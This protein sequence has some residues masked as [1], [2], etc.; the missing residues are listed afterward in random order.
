MD[1][2]LVGVQTLSCDGTLCRQQEFQ[3][4]GAGLHWPSCLRDTPFLP[5]RSSADTALESAKRNSTLMLDHV[6]EVLQGLSVFHSLYDSSD[7]MR[8]LEVDLLFFESEKN[9]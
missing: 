9:T 2:Q 4:S 6:V 3:D 8:I 7:F 1:H 5:L